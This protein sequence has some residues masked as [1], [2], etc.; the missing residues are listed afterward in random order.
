MNPLIRNLAILIILITTIFSA[1]GQE[2]KNAAA[3]IW[4]GEILHGEKNVENMVI[5]I[6]N[7]PI[8][9]QWGYMISSWQTYEL[10]PIDTVSSENGTIH[11]G[12]R[13]TRTS[14]SGKLREDGKTWECVRQTG[15]KKY[16]FKQNIILRQVTSMPAWS[17]KFRHIVYKDGFY[18]A[19]IDPTPY[20]HRPYCEIKVEKGRITEVRYYEKHDSTGELKD[21]NYGKEY[22]EDLGELAYPAAQLSVKGAAVY[23]QRLILSQDPDNLDVVTGA[24]ANYYR[25]KEVVKKALKDAI[26]KKQ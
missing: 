23:G 24:T 17:S 25:F 16:R 20:G 13:F 21:E 14:L 4:T 12:T 1:S 5:R 7:T 15:G 3:G 11:F 18:K 6:Y 2:V 10:V 26:L 8:Q 9:N 22:L 19:S